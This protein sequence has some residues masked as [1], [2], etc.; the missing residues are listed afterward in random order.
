MV[1]FKFYCTSGLILESIPKNNSIVE[2]QEA[3][4]SNKDKIFLGNSTVFKDKIIAVEI[5]KEDK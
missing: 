2:I 4:L 1:K 3:I 5:I